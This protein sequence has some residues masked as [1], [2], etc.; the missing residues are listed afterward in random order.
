MKVSLCDLHAVCVS[1]YPPINF[2]MCELIFMKLGIYILAPE[3]ISTAYFINPPI[4]L[5][6]CMYIP[7]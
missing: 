1:V 2:W 7:L 3:P 4:S 6:V 5:C